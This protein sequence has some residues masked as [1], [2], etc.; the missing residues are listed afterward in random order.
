[1][2]TNEDRPGAPDSGGR[3]RGIAESGYLRTTDVEAFPD[4]PADVADPAGS[5]EHPDHAGG[6]V[7][8][9]AHDTV[10]RAGR[11][12]V[13]RVVPTLAHADDRQRPEVGGPVR[14]ARREWA[15]AVHV[16]D[17]VDRPGDVVQQANAH[18]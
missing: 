2:T 5:F 13:V 6:W 1:M 10:T 9:A 11:V 8:L 14:S 3:Q 7:D 18:Q 16:A 4:R 15:L 17:R 12:G